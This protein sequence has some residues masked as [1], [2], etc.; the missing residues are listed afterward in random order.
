MDKATRP[1]GG[2]EFYDKAASAD[3][4][5]KFYEGHYHDML[6][7]LG[8]EQV[9]NDI[10]EWLDNRVDHSVNIAVTQLAGD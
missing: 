6:N 1:E 9:M 4:T 3:Q 5:L 2:R 7:D 10:L 8:K